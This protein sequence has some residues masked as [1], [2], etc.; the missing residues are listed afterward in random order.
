MGLGSKF[1]G[2][3]RLYIT[4]HGNTVNYNVQQ[5]RDCSFDDCESKLLGWC[6]SDKQYRIQLEHVGPGLQT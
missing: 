6:I 2:S 3:D 5:D 1:K 4:L